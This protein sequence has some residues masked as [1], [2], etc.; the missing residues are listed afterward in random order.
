MED[1]LDRDI[2]RER[3]ARALPDKNLLLA[4]LGADT[5]EVEPL[6]DEA[7]GGVEVHGR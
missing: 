6:V 1:L 3:I 5:F 4:N 7:Y 2:L